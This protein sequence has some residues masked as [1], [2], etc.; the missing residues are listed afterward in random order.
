MSGLGRAQDK[1]AMAATWAGLRAM[2]PVTLAALFAADSARP[3]A[4]TRRIA[5]PVEPGSTAEAGMR[6]DFSKT[7]LSHEAL[8]LFETLAEAAGFAAAREALFGGG[9]VNPTEGRAATHGAMRGSGTEAQVEEA[10]AL[11]ARM[12]LLV[13]A[14]HEGAL[15]EIRHCI[16][17]GIGGQQVFVFRLGSQHSVYLRGRQSLDDVVRAVL[18]RIYSCILYCQV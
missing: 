7:H 9:I 1:A 10:D 3:E 15:G 14:I 6:I 4:L 18:R 17:I 11:H 8:T 16:A 13:E 5:W 2:A 12:E